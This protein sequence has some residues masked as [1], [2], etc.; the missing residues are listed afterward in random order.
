[1][2]ELNIG[3]LITESVT[4]NPGVGEDVIKQGNSDPSK[5]DVDKSDS[6]IK[7]VA[8]RSGY[9][10]KQKISNPQKYDTKGVLK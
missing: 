6:H 5:S 3:Q 8:L 10:A 9:I 2:A 7:T 4:M 1:M